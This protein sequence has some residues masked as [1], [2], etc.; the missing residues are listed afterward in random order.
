MSNHEEGSS[1]K[2]TIAAAAKR[3]KRPLTGRKIHLYQPIT[4]GRLW[5]A[6]MEGLPFIAKGRTGMQAKRRMEEFAAAVD[7]KREMEGD[8]KEHMDEGDQE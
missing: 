4:P 5:I 1:D 3:V 8:P 7:E 6:Q 2:S